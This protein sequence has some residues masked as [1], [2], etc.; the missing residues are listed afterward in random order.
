[1]TLVLHA[2]TRQ[3]ESSTAAV[4]GLW[5]STEETSSL[6]APGA[7]RAALLIGRDS[8][9]MLTARGLFL[10]NQEYKMEWGFHSAEYDPL[11]SR[12]AILDADRDTII[13]VLDK[14][15]GMLKGAIH[16]Q[17]QTRLPLDFIPA[18]P[19]LENRLF[20]PRLPGKDGRITYTYTVPEQTD[21]G[22]ETGSVF[23][24]ISDSLA[25]HTL[26]KDMIGQEFGK[27]KSLLILKD[28]TLVVEEYFY[29]YERDDLQQIRSCTKS[30]TSLVLGIALDRH[31]VIDLEQSIFDFFPDYTHLASGGRE[32][33][34]LRNV[35]TMHAGMEWDDYPGE[36]YTCD[37]GFE[38]ILSRPM[39]TGPGESF[40]YNSGCSVLLGGVIE[41]LESKPALDY[42]RENLFQPMGIS[43]YKWENHE[44]N[45]L[46]CGHGLSMRPRDM[47]KTG[48]LVLNGGKWKDRQIVSEE[49]IRES[50]RAQVRESDYFNYGYHWW[51]RS[52]ACLQ[53]WKDP[54]ATSP[55]EPELVNAMGHGGQYILIYK[56]LDLVIVTTAS[57]FDDNGLASSKI[58]MAIERILPLF[59]CGI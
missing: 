9:G 2:C 56:D 19:F 31:P 50:T 26:M 51:H 10:K 52:D 39:V 7:D 33:I 11:A 36:L 20:H 12:L 37:D 49:W 17:D 22:L 16:V 38:Y 46:Q 30:V 4:E 28:N 59:T 35:L 54:H 40:H 32:D 58:P 29:A 6:F 42:A 18:G 41:F 55:G 13:C 24:H 57:D 43:V 1:M 44:K 15:T 47:A 48:L 34:T 14:E 5:V 3:D 21:D 27:L 25:F 23:R 45:I 53:W 8:A